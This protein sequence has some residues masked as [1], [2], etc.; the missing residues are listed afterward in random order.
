MVRS[1]VRHEIFIADRGCLISSAHLWATDEYV[2]P[3]GSSGLFFGQGSM[4]IS[5][6][7]G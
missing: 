3:K 7:R 1:A 5:P 2:T 4:N 6:L